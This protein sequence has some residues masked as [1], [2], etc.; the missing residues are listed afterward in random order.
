MQLSAFGRERVTR[1]MCGAGKVRTERFVCG[2][3]WVN[4]WKAG[5]GG[6]TGGVRMM[7]VWRDL[8]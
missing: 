5:S 6:M 1:R 8:N 2:G 4:L 7:R 3:G